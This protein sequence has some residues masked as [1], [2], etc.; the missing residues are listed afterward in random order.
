MT[1]QA[2]TYPPHQRPFPSTWNV[3]RVSSGGD[4]DEGTAWVTFRVKAD[5]A[6]EAERRVL[7]YMDFNYEDDLRGAVANAMP[8]ETPMTAQG[9]PVSRWTV[10]VALAAP[11]S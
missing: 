2:Y 1:T 9:H 8:V 6:E 7:D 11:R 10:W 3:S 5:T 4:P